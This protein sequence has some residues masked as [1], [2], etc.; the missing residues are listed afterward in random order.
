QHIKPADLEPI[1]ISGAQLGLRYMPVDS[2]GLYVP[3]GRAVLFSTLIMLA[4]PALVAGVK[5]ENISVVCPPPTRDSEAKNSSDIA[6]VVLATA[7]ILGIK[8]M[9]RLGGAQAIAALAVGSE[10]VKPVDM[11]A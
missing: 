11:I 9:Y 1:N 6:P 8:K 10:T 4:C 5:P 3:G 2:A 7:H